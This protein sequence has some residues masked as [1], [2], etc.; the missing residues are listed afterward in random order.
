MH[1]DDHVWFTRTRNPH[2]I[3]LSVNWYYLGKF[4]YRFG[5]SLIIQD[6]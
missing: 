5:L 6:Y 3:E 4:V 1:I 2:F